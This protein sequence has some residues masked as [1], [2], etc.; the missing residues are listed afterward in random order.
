MGVRYQR[1]GRAQ[2]AVRA[3]DVAIRYAPESGEAWHGKATAL[4]HLQRWSE[5]IAAYREALRRMPRS[6]LTWY[7]LG[8]AER[9]AGHRE[10]AVEAL[11][12]AVRL[13]ERNI[14]YRLELGDAWASL[15]RWTEAI[16]QW[17]AIL[18]LQPGQPDALQRLR[19]ADAEP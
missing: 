2:D 9:D 7:A 19:D 14:A 16:E 5:A 6:A 15:A 17:T 12:A 8:L 1:A 10:A 18:A 4:Y 3:Y 11:E 13:N